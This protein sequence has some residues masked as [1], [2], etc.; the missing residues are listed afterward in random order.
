MPWSKLTR[1]LYCFQ[2]FQLV[3]CQVILT[4]DM[5]N[6]AFAL[7]TVRSKIHLCLYYSA[8][9]YLLSSSIQTSRPSRDPSS[10]QRSSPPVE[11]LHAIYFR[12]KWIEK[13]GA[14]FVPLTSSQFENSPSVFESVTLGSVLERLLKCFCVDL[15]Y[16]CLVP[17]ALRPPLWSVVR[18]PGC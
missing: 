8:S 3:L 16:Y 12:Q 5:T 17:L 1:N 6:R 10:F 7:S 4:S 11:F 2:K 15:A 9:S 13:W 14:S 18:V